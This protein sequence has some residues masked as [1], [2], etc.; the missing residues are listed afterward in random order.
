MVGKELE[1]VKV[2][3]DEIMEK[4][5]W[6]ENVLEV[7]KN[8]YKYKKK[9]ELFFEERLS[10]INQYKKF[11][12]YYYDCPSPVTTVNA[13]PIP[14]QEYKCYKTNEENIRFL[15]S[16]YELYYQKK[17]EDALLFSK[18]KLYVGTDYVWYY[19]RKI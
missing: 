4:V 14:L 10:C 5:I 8:L 1:K 3:I 16:Y 18:Y 11:E 6:G 9:G 12:I 2:T 19:K 17:A 13:F 15:R 7:K